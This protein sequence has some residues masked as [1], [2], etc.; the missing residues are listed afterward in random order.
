ML[1]LLDTG[2]LLRLFDRSDTNH[3]AVR[4]SLRLLHR[5]GHQP[6]IAVQNAVEFWNVMTRPATSP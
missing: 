6:V 2:I 1:V 3:S 5:L 4:E